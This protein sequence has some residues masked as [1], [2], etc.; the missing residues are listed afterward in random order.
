[1]DSEVTRCDA[2]GGALRDADESEGYGIE[3]RG[4]YMWRRGG[5]SRFESAPLCASCASA[6]GMT[7][8]ARWEIEEE[9]G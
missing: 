7:A 6:I 5:E 2:C 8:L 3:G 1:V 9:E 4:V